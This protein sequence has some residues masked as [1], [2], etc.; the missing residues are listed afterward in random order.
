M[1]MFVQLVQVSRALTTWENMRGSHGHGHSKASDAITSALT[2][3]TTS[4]SGAQIG[5]T[6]MGPDPALPPTHAPGHNHP[7][8]K[9][10]CFAQWKKILGV[11]TF[12]ETA[13]DGVSGNKRPRSQRNPFSNGCIGNCKDFWCDPAP[14]FGKRENGAAMLGGQVVDYTAMYETPRLMIATRR[15]GGDNAGAYAAVGNDDSVWL[16]L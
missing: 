1:L 14:V 10:G 7:H 9:A 3:G 16:W 4:R 15:R 11:D 5:D 2:T 13:L 8:H 12:V 6:G